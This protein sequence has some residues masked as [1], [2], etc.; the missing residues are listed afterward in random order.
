MLREK[1]DVIAAIIGALLGVGIT[2]INLIDATVS[3][4][5][6]GPVLIITCL[7][8]LVFRQKLLIPQPEPS[9]SQGPVLAINS[10]FWFSLAGGI[11]HD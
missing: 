1:I 5:T 7:G 9:S 4:L 8:Y 10:I 6:M 3:T 2:S 11:S